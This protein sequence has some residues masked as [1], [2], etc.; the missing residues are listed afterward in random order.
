MAWKDRIGGRL[1]RR[2]LA[3][4]NFVAYTVVVTA[5]VVAANWFADRHDKRWDLTPD[6]KYSLSPQTLKVLKDLDRDVTIY[7]F[8]RE[9]RFKARRDLLENFATATRRVSVQYLDLDR[10]PALAKRLGVRNNGTIVVASSDRHF[11]TQTDDEEGVTN[12]LIRLLK[13]QKTVYFIQGHGEHDLESSESD[14]YSTIKKQLEAENYKVG[15]LVLLQKPEIPP[16]ASA[17]AVAGPKHDFEPPEIETLRK[18]LRGGGRAL[19][20]LDAGTEVP[21]LA[22]LLEEWNVALRN[23]LVIDLNPVAQLF[24]TTPDMPLIIKYGNNPIVQP[25]ARTATLFPITRSFEL[26]NDPKAGVTPDSLCETSSDSFGVANFDPKM[27]VVSFRAGRDHKGPLTVAVA[28]TMAGEGEKKAE[29]R[30]VAVGTSL[31]AANRYIKFQG[32]R[33][34][35][36]NMVNWL[37]AAEDLISIRPKPPQSQQLNLNAQQMRRVFY[38]GVLGLPGLIIALGISVWWRRR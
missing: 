9:Q 31:A 6:Q 25:L 4:A 35:F 32:N 21:N 36:M 30:F 24:G 12:T 18:Y 37:S 15:T 7:A 33:D 14:G 26:R 2:L 29:G 13:A 27:Q 3:G 5:L 28:G 8:D 34:L 11:E 17:V 38:L 23:D 10:Q 16:D 20:L 19:F 22:Q 1:G